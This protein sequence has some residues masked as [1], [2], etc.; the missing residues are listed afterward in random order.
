MAGYWDWYVKDNTEYLSPG[1]KKMFGYKDYEMENTPEAWQEIIFEEDLEKVFRVYEDHISSRGKSPYYAEVRY[2]HK[3]GSTVWVICTGK[4]IE[5]DEDWQ[6]VRIVGAHV[7]ITKLKEQQQKLTYQQ[8]LLGA[9][10]KLSPI[11]IALTDFETGS[12][13]DANEK[14]IE[15]SGFSK[16][17][18]LGLT[19][20]DLT[21]P[22]YTGNES[23]INKVMKARG[24]FAPYEKEYIRKDGSRYPVQMRGKLIEDLNGRSLVWSFIED[25]SERKAQRLKLEEALA[26]LQATLDASTQV[27]TV[28]TNN[29]GTITWVNSGA[30]RMLGYTETELVNH[31]SPALFHLQEEIEARALALSEQYGETVEGFETFVFKARKGM[32]ESIQWT[33][34]RKDGSIFP[35]IV[36]VTAIHRQDEIIGFLGVLTDISEQ[37]KTESEMRSL[38]QITESQNER[39]KNFAHIASHN[40]RSHAVGISGLLELWQEKEPGIF[41]EEIPQMLLKAAE[42]LDDTIEDLTEVVKINLSDSFFEILPLK[43][44]LKKNID[45][46]S[47]QTRRSG[48]TINTDVPDDLMVQGNPAYLNSVLL[49][50]I[51]N[52]AKYSSPERDSYLTIKA[53]AKNGYACITFEDNGLGIDLKRHG[54]KIFGMYK[55]FHKHPDSR[56]VGLF[57]AKSQLENMGG[58]IRVESEAGKGTTFTINLPLAE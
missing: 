34:K 13:I 44:L 38:L 41:D 51:T 37:K 47:V 4:V 32:A 56:G 19:N 18:L 57:L 29:S 36:S 30:E 9:L 6:P 58:T 12:F 35:S 31:A 10:F 16:D 5:W 49:N 43:K 3:D 27:G 42:N 8:N 1:F 54:H 48:L 15:Y 45:S 25:I 26:N 50:L 24:A 22:E 14:L 52:A 17:E 23:R 11:G 28:A 2:H 46:V 21:P 55:T 53:S 39:L 7:N 33:I 40:L 20:Q